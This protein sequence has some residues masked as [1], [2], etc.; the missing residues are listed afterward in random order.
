MF[1]GI[2]EILRHESSFE[3]SDAL[4]EEI[5]KPDIEKLVDSY[6]SDVLST[7]ES[8]LTD[9]FVINAIK[10]SMNYFPKK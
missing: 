1:P 3:N 2:P 9:N 4:Y 5:I 10:S 8:I 6:V 7:N